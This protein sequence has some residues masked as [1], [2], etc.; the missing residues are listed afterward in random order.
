MGRE[1]I[2]V[3]KKEK[4]QYEKDGWTVVETKYG[5]QLSMPIPEELSKAMIEANKKSTGILSDRPWW[6]R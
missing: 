2:D 6:Y 5:I 1:G 4:E 3:T